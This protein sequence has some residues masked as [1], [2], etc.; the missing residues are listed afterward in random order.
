MYGP[1]AIGVYQKGDLDHS[2]ISCITL[3]KISHNGGGKIKIDLHKQDRKHAE[4]NTIVLN[5]I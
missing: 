2:I 4:R 5:S 3:L 1:T